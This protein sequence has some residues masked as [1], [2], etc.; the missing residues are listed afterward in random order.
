MEG[1]RQYM[2]AGR[3]YQGELGEDKEGCVCE[4]LRM[5]RQGILF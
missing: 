4:A 2:M 1:S 5:P 3:R